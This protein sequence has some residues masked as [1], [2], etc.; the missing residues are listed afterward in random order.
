MTIL[1]TKIRDHAC[2][3]NIDNDAWIQM[4][5]AM[6]NEPYKQFLLEGGRISLN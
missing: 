5:N 4:Q 3:G 1:I 2:K 6:A